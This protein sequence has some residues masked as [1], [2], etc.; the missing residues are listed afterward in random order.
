[1]ADDSW[2]EAYAAIDVDASFSTCVQAIYDAGWRD[3]RSGGYIAGMSAGRSVLTYSWIG[4]YTAL[5]V[6]GGMVC[7][8]LIAASAWLGSAP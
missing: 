8:I 5:C 4:I 1:M 3:G 6:I 2:E 7:G